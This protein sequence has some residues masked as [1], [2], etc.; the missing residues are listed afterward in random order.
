MRKYTLV[1]GCTEETRELCA[2]AGCG[3]KECAE[4]C[5]EKTQTMDQDSPKEECTLEPQRNCAYVTKLVSRSTEE[6]VDV[7]KEV[8]TRS[9]TNHRKVKKP[10]VK[11]WCYAPSEESGLVWAAATTTATPAATTTTAT[12]ARTTTPARAADCSPQ[13]QFI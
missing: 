1:T 12:T 8:C 9:R 13:L 4:V 3:I 5:Q 7:S 2:T 6:C 11:E 10:V